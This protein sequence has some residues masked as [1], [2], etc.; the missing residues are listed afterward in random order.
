MFIGYWIEREETKSSLS[1]NFKYI[2]EVTYVQK[3]GKKEK[4]C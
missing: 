3:K 2:C 4:Y 1:S